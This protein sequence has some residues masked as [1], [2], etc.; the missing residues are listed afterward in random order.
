MSENKCISVIDEPGVSFD[1]SDPLGT[2]SHADVLKE[3]IEKTGTPLTIGIQGEW[4]SGKTTLLNI[5]KSQLSSNEGIKQ[6]WVNA[7]EHSL[8]STPEECLI[9]IITEIIE[10]M[11]GADAKKETR[12]KVMSAAGL[13]TKGALRI[14]ATVALGSVGSKIVDD[15]SNAKMILD[16]DI[17]AF[18]INSSCI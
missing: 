16:I 14:G 4:G 13:I 9:K 7:W 1:N 6:I 3:F 11:V 2:N 17:Y 15:V 18:N 12:D 8:L 5:I 10:E